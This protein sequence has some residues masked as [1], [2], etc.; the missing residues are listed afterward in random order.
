MRRKDREIGRDDALSIVDQCEW[1]TI[2]MNDGNEPYCIPVSIA[3]D[4]SSIYFHCAMSGRKTDILS[5][6][7]RVCV[8][9][10]GYTNRLQDEFSTEFESAVVTGCAKPVENDEEKIHALRLICQRHTPG[11]MAAFDS[12]IERSLSRTAVWKIS[13]D[14]ATGKRKRIT[15][16]T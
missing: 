2:A 9:C 16:T 10:V 8:S 13:I 5:R 15:P 1:A 4:G 6:N 7:P 11:N 14:S 3:R 12:A